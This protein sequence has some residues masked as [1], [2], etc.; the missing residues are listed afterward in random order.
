VR[1]WSVNPDGGKLLFLGEGDAGYTVTSVAC[2]AETN[3]VVSGC[4]DGTIHMWRE[5]GEGLLVL[6]GWMR[7]GE[8]GAGVTVQSVCL[9]AC[10]MVVASSGSDT[11]IKVW[12]VQG[13]Q[14]LAILQGHSANVTAI[15][16][17]AV[18][19]S[20]DNDQGAVAGGRS[21]AEE[22][23]V[24]DV[25]GKGTWLVSG[26]CDHSIKVWDVSSILA[27]VAS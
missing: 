1:V 12:R 6:C 17:A 9:S 5:G 24:G 20:P 16:F 14:M 22:V 3:L 18:L 13:Q 2:G 8:E 7:H 10:D 11:L 19:D 27:C 26:S 23:C 4:S 25:R 21:R 15:R